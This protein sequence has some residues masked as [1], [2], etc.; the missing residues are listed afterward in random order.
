MAAAAGNKSTT[1]LSLFTEAFGLEVKE[2][3]STLATQTWAEGVRTGKWPVEQREAWLN[4]VLEVQMRQVR[5][6]AGAVMCETRDLGIK[7]PHWPLICE[8]EA[9]IDM[10]YVCPKDVKKILFQRARSVYWMKWAAKHE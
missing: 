6:L 4:Q 3:L 10:R 9:R 8:G 2:E 7:R 1:S 5:E